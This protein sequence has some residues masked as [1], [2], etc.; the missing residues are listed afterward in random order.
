MEGYYNVNTDDE[1]ILEEVIRHFIEHHGYKK[2][3]F[4]SGPKGYP[5][6]DKRVASFYRI[7]SKYGLEVNEKQIYYGDF[8]KHKAYD[9]AMEWMHNHED[10]PQAIICANDYMAITICNA[11]KEKGFSV[12]RDIAVSGCD[13][14]EQSKILYHRLQQ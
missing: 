5:D 13:N 6:A 14:I 11:L 10:R 1:K 8:W 3:N 4:L 9:A 2:M 7:M 12:P